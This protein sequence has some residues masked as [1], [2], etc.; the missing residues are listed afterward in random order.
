MT[1]SSEAEA[2]EVDLFD[3]FRTSDFG[4]LAVV[5]DEA[6]IK[7]AGQCR[8]LAPF[9][10]IRRRNPSAPPNDRLAAFPKRYVV[11]RT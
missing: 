2:T 3:H 10:P 7:P 8:L 6:V 4:E 9:V 5:I 1:P 11:K